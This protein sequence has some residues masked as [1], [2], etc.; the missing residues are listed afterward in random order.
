MAA[1]FNS[2]VKSKS[3]TEVFSVVKNESAY[4]G[5]QYKYQAKLQEAISNIYNIENKSS[6]VSNV[7]TK[8]T[9][10]KS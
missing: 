6:K 8:L 7:I 3:L 1:E 2:S 9:T 4:K 5:L 10:E